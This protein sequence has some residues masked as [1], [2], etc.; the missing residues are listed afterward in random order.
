M[1]P[2]PA[3]H[4]QPRPGCGVS[5]FP[6]DLASP[7]PRHAGECGDPRGCHAAA[8]RFACRRPAVGVSTRSVAG[9]GRTASV[10]SSVQCGRR[11]GRHHP[12]DQRAS[13][14]RP[15]DTRDVRTRQPPTGQR[16]SVRS[17][18]QRSTPPW[19]RR[20]PPSPLPTDLDQLKTARLTHAG[21]RSPLALANREIGALAPQDKAAAGKRVGAA[22]G[23]VREALDRRLAELEAERDEQVLR[24][25]VVDVTL[26]ARR[27]GDGARH[28]IADPDGGDRRPVRRHGLGDR[29]GS[30]GRGRVVQ[31]RRAEL[32]RRPPGPADAGHVL[33][34]AA[35][36]GTA[37][38]GRTRRRCRRGR[39]SSAAHPCTSSVPGARSAP[40]S[41]TPRTRRSSTR[42]RG[43]RSTAGSRWRTSR[44]RWTISLARCSTKV[45]RPGCAP[46]SS[47]SPNR[48]PRWTCAASSAAGT[49]SSCR[50]CKGTGVDRVGW[51]RDGRSE[52][53]HG[54]WHRSRGLL[55]FRVRDGNRAHDDVPQRCRRHARHGRGRRPVQ[56]ALRIGGL[57]RVP[58]SWLREYAAVPPGA[59]AHEVAAALVRGRPRGGGLRRGLTCAVPVV[60][61]RVESIN[62]R[63]SIPTARPSS[64]ARFGSLRVRETTR[65]EGSSAV[66]T[67][68]CADDLVVVALPG[69]VLPGGFEIGARRTY[70][71]VSDGMICSLRELGAGGRPHRHHRAHPTGPHRR[72]R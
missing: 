42:S 50:A 32:R 12:S 61:G 56:P 19:R 10:S 58:L 16:R 69:A 26:P 66:P 29:R 40:T 20:W 59:T 25:E 65:Y 6:R 11:A 23:R 49:D 21:D 45:S 71:H 3:H 36:G 57:M 2:P 37:S 28:P 48:A 60:V 27:D 24:E 63:K 68:S 38:C 18:R 54:L 47:R 52:R 4:P 72:T 31:L 22:R 9:R 67:T 53:A 7:L 13:D 39:C 17:H 62:H 30:G 44:A 51:V 14:R 15:E 8:R 5:R 55:R 41:S 35:G 33:R 70:G 43:S 1:L 64:G 34:R 46:R